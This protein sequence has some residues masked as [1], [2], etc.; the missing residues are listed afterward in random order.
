[1]LRILM[2][3]RIV[4]CLLLVVLLLLGGTAQAD[5]HIHD[6]AETAQCWHCQLDHNQALPIAFLS[7][8]QRLIGLGFV[9]STRVLPHTVI[10]PR[11]FGRAP[12]TVS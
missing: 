2:T 11:Y 5:P 12:P 3:S 10:Y 8:C 7:H 4:P 9:T 6:D 1:M